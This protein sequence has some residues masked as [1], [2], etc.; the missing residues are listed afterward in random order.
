MSINNPHFPNKI[1]NGTTPSRTS[2]LVDR[3][4]DYE[5]WDQLVAEIVSAQQ[6]VFSLFSDAI[7]Y[8]AEI[9]E[10]IQVGQLIRLLPTGELAVASSQYGTITGIATSIDG[11]T[12]TY[13][14]RGR[15]SSEEWSLVP[16][17][18]Y[19]LNHDGFITETAPITGYVIN[20]GQAQST[21]VFDFD[22]Q[23]P[24]RL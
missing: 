9:S 16:G 8:S 13:I 12:G 2:R 23:Q 19:F 15:I 10:A 1:W 20:V 17:G 5:D 21:T 14:R 22:V 24:V 7:V 3:S 11:T 18:T 6:V 4:P